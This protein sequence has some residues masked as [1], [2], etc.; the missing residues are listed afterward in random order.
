[1]LVLLIHLASFLGV[2]LDF[3]E[4]PRPLSGERALCIDVT[5]VTLD[6]GP[7]DCNSVVE[8]ALAAFEVGP[9]DD[10]F[11]VAGDCGALLVRILAL[12]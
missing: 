9:G 10:G 2:S 12:K 8:A 4:E 1:M 5:F 6:L 3:P 7:V 11:D